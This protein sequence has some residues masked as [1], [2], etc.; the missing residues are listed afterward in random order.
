MIVVN[1]S[2]KLTLHDKEEV[3]L[4][5]DTVTE[6]MH[7]NEGTEYIPYGAVIKIVKTTTKSEE[8]ITDT[9]CNAGE[10]ETANCEG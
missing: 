1:K 10:F 6:L 8:D 7:N 4:D 5:N 3:T 9:F 2:M